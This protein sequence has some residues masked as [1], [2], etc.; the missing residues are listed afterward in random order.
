MDGLQAALETPEAKEI[1][2]SHG[3]LEPISVFAAS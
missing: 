1:E 2:K 3:V